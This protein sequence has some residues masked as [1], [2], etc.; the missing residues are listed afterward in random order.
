MTG[1][2]HYFFA[3]L[4]GLAAATAF[5]ILFLVMAG[6]GVAR[7]A[8]RARLIGDE[9]FKLT[10]WGL[11][12]GPTLLPAVDA[13]LL[14]YLGWGSV[15]ALHA[16][17]AAVGARPFWDTLRRIP[18]RWW[19]A[20]LAC[21]LAVAWSN[22]DFDWNQRLNQPLTVLDSVKHAAVVS[23]LANGGLPMSDP[24]FIRPGIA[25]Y[26]YYFYLGPALVHWLGGPLVDSRAAFSAG[27]FIILLAFPA[28]LMLVAEAA[29]LIPQDRRTRFF[30][31]VA[32]LC[33][34]SGLD[35]LPG[36]MTAAV[37]G[38]T[39]PQLDWWSDEIRWV[40]TSILWVPHHI[41]AV[42]AVFAGCLI[43]V[44]GRSLP[45]ARAA[46]VGLAFA[47]AF[48]SSVWVAVAA[49]PILAL[50][51][52]TGL[53]KPYSPAPWLLPLGGAIAAMLLVPQF[54]DLMAGRAP[55][56]TPLGFYI[57]HPSPVPGRPQSLAE[58]LTW[59]ALDPGAYLIEF[60]LFAIGA[61]AFLR[62]DK[63]AAS[64]STA[65]GQMLLLGT[66]LA[67]L[68]VTFIRSTIIFNDFG[69]R[70]IWFAQIPA[71]LWTASVLSSDRRP[72]LRA[73][74]AWAAA[75][76]L[77]LVATSWDLV[78]MRLIRPPEFKIPLAF[79]N[80][81]PEVDYDLRGAYGWVDRT[82]PANLAV[83]HNPTIMRA[84]DFG[85]YSDRRVALADG[86]ARLFGA[87][88]A[89]I[90]QRLA[91]LMPIYE[92]PMPAQQLR[93]RATAAGVGAIVLTSADPLWQAAGG[94]PRDWTCRYRSPHACVMLLENIQ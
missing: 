23:A 77:G 73:R 63:L 24:F 79:V 5:S 16:A 60:G 55:G 67:L 68:M 7:L 11:L 42:L 69:W 18:G 74:P 86:Q 25:G 37:S 93:N 9:P 49:A 52:I 91:L 80:A 75:L 40:L 2:M 45:V 8:Q 21:W 38:V 76:T 54:I 57:R 1:A 33:C 65:M 50:W 20:L 66:P 72:R 85:L 32:L 62:S 59:L 17:L 29:A 81:K 71:L 92:R 6:F 13:L 35:L 56:F 58:A 70:A 84:L 3:D 88:Q 30:A 27:S 31:I 94:P 78:G 22:V 61:I 15:L 87:D 4:R 26:Y 89:G 44:E 90:D 83:Q 51:W 46:I 12:L 14:R 43:L 39:L 48:G 36:L 19:L 10:C 34:V 82:L 64:R 53:N 28:M 41:M 47:T